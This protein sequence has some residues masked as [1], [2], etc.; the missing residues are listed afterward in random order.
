M[1]FLRE[2]KTDSRKRGKKGGR[3][4]VKKSSILIGFI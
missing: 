3:E 1:L 2:R 4:G